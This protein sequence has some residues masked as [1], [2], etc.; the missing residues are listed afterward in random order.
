[1]DFEGEGKVPG[2]LMLLLREV[3]V[4]SCVVILSIACIRHVMGQKRWIK[5]RRWS[6]QILSLCMQVPSPPS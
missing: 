4:I 3:M 2:L 5:V 1:M 6:E